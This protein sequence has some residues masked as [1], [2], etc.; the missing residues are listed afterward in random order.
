MAIADL[1][2]NDLIEW[3][4]VGRRTAHQWLRTFR[5]Q[6]HVLC[7]RV[8]VAA[9]ATRAKVG[10]WRYWGLILI[11]VMLVSIDQ[12]LGV[13]PYLA[14][15]ILIVIWA[16]FGA[17]TWCGAVNR[18]R[19]KDPEYCRNNASGLLL[20]CR[21]RQHKFQRFTRAWWS[22]SWRDRARGL[23]MG[24]PAKLATVSGVVGIITGLAGTALGI[25]D[26]VQR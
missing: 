4:W 5:R 2:W 18:K 21:I 24:A 15:T 22:T 13:L 20:G 23:W 7:S 16:L 17:P 19:G 10:V 8:L 6:P 1:V 12:H 14:M 3:N 25:W 11:A 9:A 26:V